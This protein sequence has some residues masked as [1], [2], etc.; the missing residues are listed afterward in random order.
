MVGRN[1]EK[2]GSRIL[3]FSYLSRIIYYF[4]IGKKYITIVSLHLPINFEFFEI[5]FLNIC[6]VIHLIRFLNY[7]K[8]NFD[9]F[10][11]KTSKIF[12]VKCM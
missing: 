2:I 12:Q 11:H 10:I 5:L 6:S 9:A 4:L 1:K 8:S 7:F 3:E